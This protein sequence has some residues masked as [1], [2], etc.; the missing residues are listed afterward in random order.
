MMKMRVLL[1][2]ALQASASGNP[3]GWYHPPFT[4]RQY[5]ET[6]LHDGMFRPEDVAAITGLHVYDPNV[7]PSPP[8]GLVVTCAFHVSNVIVN[9][10]LQVSRLSKQQ[11]T[12]P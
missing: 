8:G 10:R 6:A 5:S 9:S 4:N 2:A 12:A 11:H 3:D 1:A 7:P